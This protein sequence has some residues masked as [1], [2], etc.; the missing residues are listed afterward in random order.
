L[1]APLGFNKGLINLV[2]H[3]SL[4]NM[5]EKIIHLHRAA[6]AKPDV[7]QP[8][9]GCGV[10]CALE[11]CPVARLR[12]LQKGGPCP[13]LEWS[14]QERRYHCGMLVRPG[15]YFGWLPAAGEGLMRKLL[16][17]WIAA[18]K[19]CDCSASAAP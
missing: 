16:K 8:C 1:F 12:F 4:R 17:R 3:G 13:A 2:G 7:G 9:N 5:N 18:G 15:A 6:P 14:D 19:G 10:C 11:T